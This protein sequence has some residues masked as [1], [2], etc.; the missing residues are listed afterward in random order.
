MTAP[1]TTITYDPHLLPK[2][3]AADRKTALTAVYQECRNIYSDLIV[4]NTIHSLGLSINELGGSRV[5]IR[6]LNAERRKR[7]ANLSEEAAA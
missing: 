3:S 5:V 6:A 7:L 2:M 1:I 4:I